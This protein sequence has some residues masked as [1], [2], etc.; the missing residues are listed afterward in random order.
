MGFYQFFLD[1]LEKKSNKFNQIDDDLI[2]IQLRKSSTFELIR[3]NSEYFT[4]V[5]II[6]HDL[7]YDNSSYFI[8][9]N[10]ATHIQYICYENVLIVEI[11]FNEIFNKKDDNKIL[12]YF[13]K[14]ISEHLTEHQKRLRFQIFRSPTGYHAFLINCKADFRNREDI[15]LM[16]KFGCDPYQVMGAYLRGWQAQVSPN[17]NETLLGPLKNKRYVQI[18]DVGYGTVDQDIDNQVRILLNMSDFIN[19]KY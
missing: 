8:I 1:F 13:G 12:L 16:L 18:G 9:E 11:N 2:L 14:K 6:P 10:L 15:E 19:K 5:F 3:K 7:I 17:S 4:D